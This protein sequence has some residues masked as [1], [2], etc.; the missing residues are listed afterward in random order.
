M[1]KLYKETFSLKEEVKKL[2]EDKDKTELDNKILN[3]EINRL[4]LKLGDYEKII[5]E[6]N[7]NNH[8][9]NLVNIVQKE[10]CNKSII[11]T[12][13][14]AQGELIRMSQLNDIRKNSELIKDLQLKLDDVIIK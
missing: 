8:E 6:C 7:R 14:F 4:K 10:K 1:M 9:L 11:D 13:R 2:K 5:T 12:Y 3:E